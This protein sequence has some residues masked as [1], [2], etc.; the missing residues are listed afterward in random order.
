MKWV[1]GQDICKDGGFLRNGYYWLFNTFA[2][3]CVAMRVIGSNVSFFNDPRQ[4]DVEDFDAE[5]YEWARFDPPES[6]K[7]AE[8]QFS[9]QST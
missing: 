2:G 5:H 3:T 4:W 6:K 8:S 1:N 9:H 7:L